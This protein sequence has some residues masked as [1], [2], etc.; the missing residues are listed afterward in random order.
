MTKQGK[1]SGRNQNKDAVC[2][3]VWDLRENGGHA[4]GPCWD[5]VQEDQFDTIPFLRDLR[6]RMTS[7]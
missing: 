2:S 5:F 6:D 3:E 4:M 7:Q 1:W